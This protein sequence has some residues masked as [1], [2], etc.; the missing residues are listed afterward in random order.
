MVKRP[1]RLLSYEDQAA[2]LQ[3][4]AQL[5]QSKA[6]KQWI[7]QQL[8]IRYDLIPAVVQHLKSL[9]CNGGKS[10]D[11]QHS[12]FAAS[13][14]SGPGPSTPSKSSSVA[15]SVA[16]CR[17]LG[18]DLDDL[19]AAHAA[20]REEE[21]PNPK[22]QLPVIP[23]KYKTWENVPTTYLQAV[24]KAM[25]PVA[26]SQA[27]LRSF[28]PKGCKYLLKDPLLS[29]LEFCLDWDRKAPVP[30]EQREVCR[31]LSIAKD[32]NIAKGRRAQSLE[33]PCDWGR[34]G[35]YRLSDTEGGVVITAATLADSPTKLVQ[36][37]GCFKA[38][39]SADELQVMDNWNL[40]GAVLIIKQCGTRCPAL[41]F[42]QGV[43]AMA[44]ALGNGAAGKPKEEV[45]DEQGDKEGMASSSHAKPAVPKDT[46]EETQEPKSE[47]EQD[48]EKQEGEFESQGVDEEGIVPPGPADA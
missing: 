16:E 37:M 42:F 28:H 6:Q 27:N 38:I 46:K 10:D 5:L 31:L 8:K 26:F 11:S 40:L 43:P 14:S 13:P 18:M 47:M 2:E 9:G 25:E 44:T 15:G 48:P 34:D 1:F 45:K 22:A 7:D 39:T 19:M 33:L 41:M 35:H 32:L 29:L 17:D 4:K 24:L 20:D 12:Q 23:K 30:S 3:Q 21:E 36:S